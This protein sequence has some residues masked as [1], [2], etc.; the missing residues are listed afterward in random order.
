LFGL[1]F[2]TEDG[3]DMFLRKV[4]WTF[5]ELHDIISQKIGISI[6]TALRNTDPI[7]EVI[8]VFKQKKAGHAVA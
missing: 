3:G 6:N 5:N 7:Y 8:H 1:S 4:C 2:D